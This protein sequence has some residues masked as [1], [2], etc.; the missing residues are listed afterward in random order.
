VRALEE[1][2]KAA[3]LFFLQHTIAVTDVLIGAR[4]LSDTHPEIVL[5]RLFTE[6]AL[7]RHIYVTVPTG[8]GERRVCIEPDGSC[9]FTIQG[10]VEDFF[11]IEVYRTLPPADWRFKQKVSGYVTAVASGQHEALFATPALSIAVFAQTLPMARTLKKWTEE[12]L[13]D[14]RQPEQ[15]ERFFFRSGS[16]ADASP[17]ELFLTPCWEQP[18]TTTK[19]PLI[20]REEQ[21]E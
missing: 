2:Q 20:I 12:V 13:Q 6:R 16:V 1:Q 10:N 7:R 3:N 11:H 5:T 9:E 15:A 19:T 8:A 18:L 17:Q 21:R 4:L 14:I